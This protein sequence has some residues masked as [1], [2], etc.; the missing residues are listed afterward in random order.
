MRSACSRVCAPALLLLLLLLLPLPGPT[1]TTRLSAPSARL[2][3]LFGSFRSPAFPA[4]YPDETRRRWDVAVPVGFRVRLYFSHF[5][6]EPSDSCQC[7]YVKVEAEDGSGGGASLLGVFCGG[8]ARDPESAPGEDALL[9]PANALS[10]TFSSDFSNEEEFGGFVAHYSA[11]DVDECAEDEE[12]ACDH[13][14]H[15]YAGGFYCSCRRGYLLH[16]DNRTCKGQSAECH[17]AVYREP[18]GSLSSPDFPSPYPKSSDCS[19]VIRAPAGRKLRLRFDDAFDVE[20]HPEA[21]CPY[22]YVEIQT[23]TGELGPFCGRR[24]PGLIRIDAD[25]VVVSFHSD[26]LGENTGWRMTY[27]S[28][29]TGSVCT[30]PTNVTASPPASRF[31]S[32]DVVRVRCSPGS[33][34]VKDGERVAGGELELRCRRDGTWDTALPVCQTVDCGTPPNVDGARAAFGD[35]HNSTRFGAVVR[36]VCDDAY[37]QIR[38]EDGEYFCGPDGLWVN[39]AAGAELP[40]CEPACGRPSRPLAARAK[41][42]VGGRAA[43]PGNFPWQ[44]LLSVEDSSRVPSERRFGSGALLSDAWVL[45]AAH[46]L[47]SRRRRVGAVPVDP[48]H[49][50]VLAGVVDKREAGG[51]SVT[52]VV[53]HPDFRPSDFDNDIALVRLSVRVAL[54]AA[55]RPICLPPPQQ[56]DAPAAPPDTLGAVAGWGASGTAAASD[57]LRFARLPVVP[58]DECRASYAARPGGGYNVTDNMFCAGFYEG[59]RDTCPGDSGGAFA[60]PDPV[61]GRWAALGL[62][63]WAGPEECGARR[64]YGVYTRVDRY[65]EWIRRCQNAP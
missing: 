3:E 36:Y 45:S 50:K 35:R 65:L 8:R 22:D 37:R 23:A 6:L 24:S 5:D 57:L 44:V 48:R 52:R 9:S 25:A 63:S 60:V 43:E 58:Q 56:G 19:Y 64:V 30:P 29:E 32:G 10:V 51:L 13:L 34:F 41:R 16:G 1:S 7:D 20:D 11:V 18:A 4:A 21:A 47:S 42:V 53:L 26:H 54:A 62:V 55:V 39:R 27:T 33:E 12:A 46:V 14:C 61:T 59:G 49:V 2:T 17:G 31:S 38:P 40:T 28:E 15:N